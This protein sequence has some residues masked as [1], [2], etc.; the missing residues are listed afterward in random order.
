M[1]KWETSKE[2]SEFFALFLLKTEN[3]APDLGVARKE[4]C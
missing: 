3:G 2:P 1:Y 4:V